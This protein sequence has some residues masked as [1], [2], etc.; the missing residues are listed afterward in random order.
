[1]ANNKNRNNNG[2]KLNTNSEFTEKKEANA[3][4]L[5]LATDMSKFK[6]PSKKI[7]MERLSEI[8]GTDF[9]VEIKELIP[10]IS[11]EIFNNCT[12][13]S[14][15][16]DVNIDTRKL[17]NRTIVE[18]TFFE[19][20]Q[21]FKNADLK[22]KFNAKTPFDLLEAMTTSKEREKLFNLIENLGSKGDLFTEV[23]N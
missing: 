10:A 21:L 2:I 5:L 22:E 3:I 14:A 19:G 13:I 16:G 17:Q 1:M 9:I 23:K 11:E 4:E 20:S 8:I 18:A 7:K 6:R 15:T 12:N